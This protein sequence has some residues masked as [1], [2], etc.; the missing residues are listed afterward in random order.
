MKNRVE[1]R[2]LWIDIAKGI[3]IITIVLLHISSPF[4]K[5]SVGNYLF[6]LGT[7]YDVMV[8]FCIAGLTLKE[9]RLSDTKSFLKR[10]F[11]S[12]YLKTIL[13]GL[14][15]ILLH[16]AFIRIGY[17]KIGYDY[18]SKIMRAYTWKDY[19]KQGFATLLFANREVLIGPMWYADALLLALGV[20][21]IIH[22][23][24]K[25]L[26]ND[27]KMICYF[28]FLTSLLLFLFSSFLTIK[29][30][31]NIPRFNNTLTAVFLIDLMQLLFRNF[32]VK[33]NNS[34]VF[35][36]TALIML[37]LAFYGSVGMSTNRLIDPAFLIVAA[38]CCS[39]TIFFIS[40]RLV[41][42]V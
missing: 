42:G 40:Q 1:H 9:D 15:A 2:I 12:L 27:Q 4:W 26:I 7:T 19:L 18:N 24:L 30:N 13:V 17:Y 38:I 5:T 10:K 8:F 35:I 6:N 14:C 25:K 31:R 28:R 32:K 33:F 37:N 39:Y 23:I 11:H 3:L 36:L 22:L 21:A 16:N 20:L 29:V 34:K 41:G